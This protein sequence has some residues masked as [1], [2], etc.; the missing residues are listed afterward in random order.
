MIIRDS[1]SWRF[2]DASSFSHEKSWA[3]SQEGG[4]NEKHMDHISV[5][6]DTITKQDVLRVEPMTIWQ[7][8]CCMIFLGCAGP[9]GVFTIPFVTALVGYFILGNVTLAF[10][11]LAIVLAPLMFLPQS[12]V[13]ES[14]T[15]WL[16]H[17]ILKYFSYRLLVC[18]GGQ[19]MVQ[20]DLCR[21]AAWSL[22]VWKYVYRYSKT[23]GC[24]NIAFGLYISRLVIMHS[25]LSL[26]LSLPL[27]PVT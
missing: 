15:S 10:Q 21:P 24:R 9:T 3:L 26:F 20:Q 18:K 6:M 14:L 23:N 5:S 8:A 22:P 27:V 2:V 12:F 19:I 1:A 4:E 13:K 16:S 17:M 7:E 25:L 11:G